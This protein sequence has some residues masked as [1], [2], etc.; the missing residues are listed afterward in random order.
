MLFFCSFAGSELPSLLVNHDDAESA[1]RIAT[2]VAEGI[3]PARVVALPP[4]AFVAEIVDAE[5]E[6]GDPTT[7][8]EL[9][10][11]T[12]NALDML[13]DVGAGACGTEADLS[14]AVV[15]CELEPG[16]DGPHEATTASGEVAT[17]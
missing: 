4:G 2:Q 16:H 7:A 6:D 9:L 14:G 1:R 10:D 5:D 17:W 8:V 3:E 12:V 11:H 15:T 13:D